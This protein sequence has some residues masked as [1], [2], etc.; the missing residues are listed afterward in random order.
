MRQFELCSLDAF[1]ETQS[2]QTQFIYFFKR[3]LPDVIVRVREP[4]EK[5]HAWTFRELEVLQRLN[6]NPRVCHWKHLFLPLDGQL[7]MSELQAFNR[8]LKEEIEEAIPKRAKSL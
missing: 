1:K 5:M 4:V 3:G 8:L 6:D 7:V 2:P